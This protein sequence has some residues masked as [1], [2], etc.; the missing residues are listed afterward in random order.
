MATDEERAA[1]VAE[2]R[3]FVATLPPERYP[4]T[5]ALLPHGEALTGD[6]QFDYGLERILDGIEQFQSRSR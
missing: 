3:A 1:F 5:L 2:F 6:Q 4:T